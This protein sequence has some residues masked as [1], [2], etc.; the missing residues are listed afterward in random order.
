MRLAHVARTAAAAITLCALGALGMAAAN[1]PAQASTTHAS[2]ASPHSTGAGVSSAAVAS[3]ATTSAAS[4]GSVASRASAG[5][6]APFS[7]DPVAALTV[8]R[9]DAVFDLHRDAAKNSSMTVTET[10]AVRFPESDVNH[11]IERAI[12]TYNQ[13]I[14][15]HPHV[16]SITD[17]HGTPQPYATVDSDDAGYGDDMMVLRIGDKNTYVHGSKTY[18]IRYTLKNVVW[19]FAD[20]D[21]AE[22]YWDVNGTGWDSVIGEASVRIRLHDGTAAALNGKKACYPS[23]AESAEGVS[24]KPCTI[25]SE[26]DSIVSSVQGLSYYKS[27]TVAIGFANS[28]FAEPPHAQQAWQ[29][30]VVPWLFFIPLLAGV[31]WVIYLRTGPFRDARGRGIIVPEYDAP[32]GVWP[33][34]A[35]DFLGKTSAAFPA[36]LVGL[37]VRK[38]LTITENADAPSS[39]RYTVTLLTTNWS[40]LDQSEISLLGALFPKA[41]VGRRR[42]LDQTD[43]SLGDA[44]ATQRASAVKRVT[45]LGLRTRP[46]STANRWVRFAFL[47]LFVLSIGHLAFAAANHAGVWWVVVPDVAAAVFALVLLALSRRRL[48]ITDDGARVRDHLEGLRQYI[49]LAEKDRLAFLQSPTTAERIDVNDS[50][51]VIKLYEK[52]LPYAMVLGVSEQWVKVLQDRYATTG[53]SSPDWYSGPSPFLTLA[54]WSSAVSTSSFATTPASSSGSSSS[55]GGSG[56]GGFSGGGGGGG[57]GGGW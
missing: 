37:A 10:I 30:T 14:A 3:R 48:R 6:V 19:H 32:P 54:L 20:T 53:E 21:D 25:A 15:L 17:V 8:D 51:A 47:V 11:G 24:E 42:V 5:V 4:A 41:G 7:A 23:A 2:S 39:S 34:L 26:R 46:K 1:A 40:G 35:A 16:V 56:G 45:E 31:G 22:L 50:G 52:V 33:M 27:L 43:R 9:F 36:E 38:Y 44:L 29:W 55:F 18:V 12:P 57:G 13:D 49:E 28:A